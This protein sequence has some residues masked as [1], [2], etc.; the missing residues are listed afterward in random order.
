MKPKVLLISAALLASFASAASAQTEL[1]AYTIAGRD[2]TCQ[3]FLYSPNEHAGLHLAY[4]TDDEKW[5][6]VGQLCSSDYGQWGSQ[7]RM[8]TPFVVKAK[9]GTW[10]ALWSVN[11]ESPCF[12]VAYSDDLINWRPQDYPI[13]AEKGVAEP[14]AYQMEDGSFDIYIKT[15]KGKRYVH[16]SKDFRTFEEDS[17]AATADEVLWM[18]DEA[19][20]DGKTYKGNSFEVPAVHLNYMRAWFK[21]LA[22]EN[23]ENAKPMPKTDADLQMLMAVANKNLAAGEKPVSMVDGQLMATL[24]V[25]GK[26]KAIST[27]LM[28]I[29]F[30]DI[31]RAADGGLNA[32]MLQNGDFEYN[33]SD[34]K[35]W[36]ATTAW[37]GVKVETEGGIS[38][39][40]S[41]YAVVGDTPIYN[42]GWDGFAKLLGAG[43]QAASYDVSF[44]ARNIDGKKKQLSV[45]L[46]D[47]DGVVIADAK[48]KVEGSEW[49]AYKVTLTVTEKSKGNKDEG[50]CFVILP[51]GENKVGIDLVSMM[52]HDTYKGHGLRKDLAE[53]IAALQP[54]FVRFPGG[55]MLHGDGLGNIYHWKESVGP[56]QD[57]KPASNIWGYHQ[58]RQLGFYE[59]FQFCE[60]MGAEPLPVLAAGVPCQNS[61]LDERGL[62]GQQG[63]IP[64]ADMPAYVQDVLDLI[65]WA[66]GDPATSKWAKMRA[67]AGHPAPFGL[68]MIGIGNEDLISTIFEQRY[69]MICK[70][71]KQKYPQI[72]VVGTVGPFHWP[73]ADYVEGW[74]LANANRRF[75]D[76]VDEH[77]YEQ[78]GWFLNHQDYYDQYDR[79]APKVYL[80]EYASRGADATDNALAEGIYLCSVERNADVV[81]MSSYAPLLSKDGYSNWSPDMIY[82]DNN[83]V[84]ASES[85]EMQKLFSVHGGDIYVES[86][87][88]LP[89]PLRKYVGTSVVRDSKSGKTWLKVVNALP[90]RL[91]L[92]IKGKH[93]NTVSVEA[94]KAAVFEL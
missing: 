38:K 21:A 43:C 10:R 71:V 72:E 29:F 55:C 20:I 84:R 83:K 16:G 27:K 80:G 42:I 68:K 25:E 50:V 66:N 52:P 60:D 63:G 65:E 7:K 26:E 93:E 24:V 41:H 94:R 67:D 22:A 51:K 69:L 53:T 76:A 23:A 87:L 5:R 35:E 15:A 2:T 44:Y 6:D 37:T 54:K 90:C 28:G 36:K 18:R 49:T 86:A 14:V 13:V 91:T 48:V 75:I 8:Y 58:T 81:E 74:K 70:A 31:S 85:Y 61:K 9:D 46:V 79:K 3:I 1:P 19:N 17:L 33:A 92:G 45:A 73:S 77:Y 59:Y 56:Q 82:F 30:E 64:M 40:N 34:R 11:S 32:E 4:L 47:K 12:A 39:N 62:G 89:A 88:Q 57:R 78:P